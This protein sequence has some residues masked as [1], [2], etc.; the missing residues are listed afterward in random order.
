MAAR[1]RKLLEQAPSWKLALIQCLNFPLPHHHHTGLPLPDLASIKGMSHPHWEPYGNCGEEYG[2][3]SLPGLALQL[4]Y[5][6]SQLCVF[7]QVS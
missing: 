2:I 4:D 3:R 5:T 6:I 1:R 7:G